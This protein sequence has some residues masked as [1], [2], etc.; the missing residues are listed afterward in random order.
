[1]GMVLRVWCRY[2]PPK[3][4]LG[5]VIWPPLVAGGSHVELPVSFERKRNKQGMIPLVMG[6]ALSVCP[7]N[8]KRL[9]FPVPIIDSMGL[10]SGERT[11][12]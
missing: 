7:Q 10:S 4:I 12:G 9:N 11:V 8:P 3:S 5:E 1:L 2:P 6:P